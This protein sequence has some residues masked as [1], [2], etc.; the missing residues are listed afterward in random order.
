MTD[1]K[2]LKNG[3]IKKAGRHCLPFDFY[4]VHY[5]GFMKEGND[6]VQVLDSRKVNNGKPITF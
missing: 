3:S 5:K 6:M 2:V 1:I 4:T